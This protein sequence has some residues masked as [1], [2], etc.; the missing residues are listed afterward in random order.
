MVEAY[1]FFFGRLDEFFLGK[2]DD[3]PMNVE[4]PIASRMEECFQAMKSSL[5]VVIIDLG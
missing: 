4:M 1:A 5:Q 2:E 3:P